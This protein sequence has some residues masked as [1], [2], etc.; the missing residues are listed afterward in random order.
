MSVVRWVWIALYTAPGG[1]NWYR[2]VPSWV[3]EPPISRTESTTA[4]RARFRRRPLASASAKTSPTTGANPKSE[5]PKIRRGTH[6]PPATERGADA[7][8][9]TRATTNKTRKVPEEGRGGPA[10]RA[11]GSHTR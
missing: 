3:N 11:G 2:G 4:I 5:N 1:R 7:T 10:A 9:G 6:R 8:L